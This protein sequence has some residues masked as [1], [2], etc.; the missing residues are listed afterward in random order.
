MTVV[1]SYRNQPAIKM[2]YFFGTSDSKAYQVD[3]VLPILN[4]EGID[5][6]LTVVCASLHILSS[7]VHSGILVNC[8]TLVDLSLSAIEI[9]KSIVLQTHCPLPLKKAFSFLVCSLLLRQTDDQAIQNSDILQVSSDLLT[10]LS[11]KALSTGKFLPSNH[12]SF[13]TLCASLTD[14]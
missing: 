11:G 8:P 9:F 5:I 2:H 7:L 6:I 12:D 13:K 1:N 14:A 3:A 10:K 4:L